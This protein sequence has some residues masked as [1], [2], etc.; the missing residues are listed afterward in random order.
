MSSTCAAERCK[1]RDQ[2]QQKVQQDAHL[3]ELLEGHPACAVRV[4]TP[5]SL[6]QHILCAHV[7]V[8]GGGGWVYVWVWV[9]LAH[10]CTCGLRS[11]V[12]TFD[13]PCH[14]C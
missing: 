1:L 8:L 13:T 4:D 12:R 3:Q 10:M 2:S 11:C 5:E 7:C 9:R 6:P 14:D